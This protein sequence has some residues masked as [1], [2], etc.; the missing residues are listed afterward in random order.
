[1]T[2][3]SKPES[4]STEPT[5][6]LESPTDS[7]PEITPWPP[8]PRRENRVRL[9]RHQEVPGLL[10]ID[11]AHPHI[12]SGYADLLDRQSRGG[13]TYAHDREF[14]RRRIEE[15]SRGTSWYDRGSQSDRRRN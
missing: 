8:R 12:L 10:P 14:Q 11:P 13:W 9:L 1:M 6:V 2:D 3:Q 7:A 15:L 4:S 5:T